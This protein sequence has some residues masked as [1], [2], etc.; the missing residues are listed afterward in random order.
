MV[1]E[2]NRSASSHWPRTSARVYDFTVPITP[3]T[4]SSPTASSSPT[5]ASAWSAPISS[6]ATSKPQLRNWWKR[7][8]A[9]CPPAS[10]GRARI[11]STSKELHRLLGGRVALRRRARPGE[12]GDIDHTEADG[13][14]RRRRPGP[15]QRPRPQPRRR[16]VRHARLGQSLP[17]SAGRR[18]VFDEEA[19]KVMGLEK[20]MVCVMIHSGSRGLG[21]QVCDDALAMLRKAPA[22]VR[23]RSARTASRPAPDRQPGGPEVHRRHARRRQFRLV[24]S[25]AAR[26]SRPARCSPTSSAEPGRHCR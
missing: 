5:A 13:P 7:C 1:W 15:G 2:R 22:E 23:H 26:C 25:P 19:A 18:S 20:D 16:T 3:I 8:S 24:Q 14:A 21:Y 12:R 11:R 10:A 6:T 17:R 9:P 4:T